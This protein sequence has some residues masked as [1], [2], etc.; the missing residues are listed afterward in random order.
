MPRIKG[1]PKKFVSDMSAERRYRA[2][3]EIIRGPRPKFNQGYD[4]VSSSSVPRPMVIERTIVNQNQIEKKGMDTAIS[5][6]GG[7]AIIS[8]T[9]TNGDCFVLNLVQQGAGSWNR[10]GRKIKLRS[11]RLRGTLVNNYQTGIATGHN[12]VRMVVVW[13][14][15]PSSGT[16]PTFDTVFGITS[17][18]GTES[19]GILAPNRYDNMGR[20][21]TLRD[22][23]YAFN[24]ET[25]FYDTVTPANKAVSQNIHFDEYLKLGGK[26]TVFSGQ[27]APMTIAD[28]STG[29][30]YV[31]FRAQA[32]TAAQFCELSDLSFARLRYTE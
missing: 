20:F 17:Q 28:I 14:K 23:S 1:V 6:T 3:Q 19:S 32:S 4:V 11:L 12:I 7:N 18:A 29:A 27:T 22:C 9:N 13:D 5:I 2:T 26:E 31:Y 25:N 30:L 24:P 21:L 8:T 10:V 16:I 15:Q